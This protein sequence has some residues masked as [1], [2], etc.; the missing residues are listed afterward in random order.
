MLTNYSS[1]KPHFLKILFIWLLYTILF[2]K[3]K[4]DIFCIFLIYLIYTELFNTVYKMVTTIEPS[5]GEIM[6]LHVSSMVFFKG[7][8]LNYEF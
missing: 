7:K 6:A 1:D 8:S 4:I 3:K 2:D 5:V